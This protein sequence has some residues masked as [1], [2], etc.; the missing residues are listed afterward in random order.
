MYL[1]SYGHLLKVSICMQDSIGVILM[2]LVVRKD[3]TIDEILCLVVVI[4]VMQCML[5]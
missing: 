3:Q 5:V 2:S 4:Y 1:T